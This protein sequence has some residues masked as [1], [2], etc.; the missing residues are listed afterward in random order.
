M[1]A[2]A[3][4]TMKDTVADVVD[5]DGLYKEGC[6]GTTLEAF[7]HLSDRMQLSHFAAPPPHNF[8]ALG[9]IRKQIKL[10]RGELDRAAAG[11][12]CWRCC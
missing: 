5:A 4:V 7:A 8:N 2:S 9:A 10:L 11:V 12:E 1:A 3:A 6:G